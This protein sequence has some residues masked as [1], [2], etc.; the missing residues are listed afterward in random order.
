MAHG[1]MPQ[2]W[3]DARSVIIYALALGHGYTVVK[4]P[5]GTYAIIHTANEPKLLKGRLVICRT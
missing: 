2:Q 1:K 4:N 5:Q 3:R